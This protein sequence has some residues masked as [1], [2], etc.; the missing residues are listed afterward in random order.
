MKYPDYDNYR[1]MYQK[2]INRENL[3]GMMDLVDDYKDKN[4][5]DICAGDGAATREALAR[6]AKYSLV[7][8]QEPDMLAIDLREGRKE[9]CLHGYD[10]ERFLYQ[11]ESD[12]NKIKESSFHFFD[13]VFCRQ[14]INYW[15]KPMH[16]LQLAKWMNKDGVFIFNTFNTKPTRT[17]MVKE[18][19]IDHPDYMIKDSISFVEISYLVDDNIVHHVQ[20]REGYPPHLTK[21]RWIS[22]EEFK[23]GLIGNFDY[24]IRRRN[25]T[26]VYICRKK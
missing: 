23:N 3:L 18:Y 15:Y 8:D 1:A 25:N 24:E 9:I 4:F 16:M 13:I 12:Y 22:E 5:M 7:I 19:K 11:K 20:I 2:Y 10:F 26:D 14:G 21:F 6:G 17:P